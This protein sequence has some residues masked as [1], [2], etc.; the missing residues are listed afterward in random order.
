MAGKLTAYDS[1][2][3]RVSGLTN[4]EAGFGAKRVTCVAS[5]LYWVAIV[6]FGK[7][8]RILYNTVNMFFGSCQKTI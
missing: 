4:P 1:P 7:S 2:D 3:R 8:Y 5:E 6:L